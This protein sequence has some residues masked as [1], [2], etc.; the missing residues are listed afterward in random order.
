MHDSNVLDEVIKLITKIDKRVRQIE[1]QAG[2]LLGLSPSQIKVLVNIDEK[3]PPAHSQLAKK[4]HLSKGTLSEILDAME[5]KDIVRRKR[6]NKDRRR[7]YITLTPK[8][9]S[10][11]NNPVIHHSYSKIY[12]NLAMTD[13]EKKLLY[14][15]LKKLYNHIS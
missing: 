15:L 5:R 13:L 10:L 11:K 7:I 3:A 1:K 14:I 12:H 8:G 4:C 6:C 9:L 2:I